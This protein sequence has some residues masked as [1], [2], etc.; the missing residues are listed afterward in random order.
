[1]ANAATTTY[2]G[3]GLA[4]DFQDVIFDISPEETPL[5][6]MCK[7]MKANAVL[8][9]WQTDTLEAAGNNRRVE[10]LEATFGTLAA[11]T[12]LNNYCQISSK[13]VEV[14]E[15]YDAVKKYG[16]KSQLAYEL[17][18]AG[19]ALKRD[20][21][22]GAVRNQASSAG[23]GS[24]VARS[25]AG[26]ES[27]ING[28]RVINAGN[29][30]GTTPAY[31]S[32]PTVAPTDGTAG[33]FV[34]SDLV[35]ALELA[36]LDGGEPSKILMSSANKKR[37][38]AFAGIATKYNEVKGRSQGIVTGAADVYVSDFGNH[39]VHLDR[40]MRDQAVLC[41]DPEYIGIATLR[42]IKKTQLA[43]TGDSEKWQINTEWTL[44]MLNPNAHAK[45][46]TVGL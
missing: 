9:Q 21:E 10:G 29:T 18:K 23:A 1:M 5:V 22:F 4:E 2:T 40:F 19:K 46:M 30:T 32:S 17:V 31:T 3:A 11:T 7:K 12:V 43:K 38:S 44:A 36:W 35:S 27:W 15:T 41:I 26:F 6:S 39:T 34:E 42:P 14:S 16:R 37:F 28:N 24:S 8:H 20:M 13:F 25:S 45:V 33:T